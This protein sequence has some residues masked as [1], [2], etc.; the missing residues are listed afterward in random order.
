MGTLK[1]RVEISGRGGRA[2]VSGTGVGFACSAL[3]RRGSSLGI[4]FLRLGIPTAAPGGLAV[5]GPASGA[6]G[7]AVPAGEGFWA[8]SDILFVQMK[9]FRFEMLFLRRAV[10]GIRI[11]MIRFL[12]SRRS[13]CQG[14]K[15]VPTVVS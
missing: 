12:F 7:G 6:G 14:G 13:I 11:W 10:R 4:R 9:L 3:R 2:G 8:V 15:E 1:D 5:A